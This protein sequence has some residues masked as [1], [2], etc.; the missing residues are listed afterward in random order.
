MSPL[1]P[2]IHVFHGV[3]WREY[4]AQRGNL[5]DG[6]AGPKRQS[7]RRNSKMGAVLRLVPV[8]AVTG[9]ALLLSRIQP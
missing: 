9:P 6:M 4:Q 3:N 1:S 8:L 2:F 7:R 5:H